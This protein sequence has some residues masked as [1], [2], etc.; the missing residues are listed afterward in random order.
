M[1]HSILAA[2]T[3]GSMS[4]GLM[5][6]E[7]KV[8][9]T[10]YDDTPVIPGS[11]YRVHDKS[12]PAPEVVTPHKDLGGAPSDAIV[13]F[14]G[15]SVEAFRDKEGK[16][17]NWTAKDG[18]L[19]TGKGDIFTKESFGSCQFHIEWLT[20]PDTEGNSQ[21]KGNAGV[22]FMDRYEIQIL[23][24]YNNPTY[25]DGIAGS[26]YGQTPALKNAVR[27]PGEWQ[28]YDIIFNAPKL[29]D[30]KVVAPATVTVI[31]NGVV[32]QNNT[33]I[34]GPTRHKDI[35]NYDGIFPEKAPFRIQDHKNNPPV[36]FRNIWV[37]PL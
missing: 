17:V 11:K 13:L 20:H 21:K 2:L 3:L 32:V 18:E 28:S 10:G 6:Q 24:A 26:V 22:F 5:G 15:K 27:K 23:D 25:A 8:H 30:G 16:P 1:K 7:K 34:Q 19:I 4:L 33:V 14:D 36:K 12:R 9:P 29:K 37:R 31:V 35:T